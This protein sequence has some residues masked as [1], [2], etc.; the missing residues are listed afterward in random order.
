MD[1]TFTYAWDKYSCLRGA[2]FAHVVFCYFVALSG[3]ACLL[4][5]LWSRLHVAHAWL[6]RVY[7]LSMIWAMASSLLIHNTGLPT[8]T[9]VSFVWVLG[10]LTIGWVIISI[11][12]ARMAAAATAA[13]AVR[14]KVEGGVV[15]GGDLAALIA[16]ERGRL[17]ASKGFWARF[18][19]LKALHGS[20]M[21]VSWINIVGRIF[22]SNQSGDFTCYTYRERGVSAR[23][24]TGN[25]GNAAG[26][27]RREAA[28]LAGR[29]GGTHQVGPG[30]CGSV[31]HAVPAP[32]PFPGR[33][34][35]SSSLLQAD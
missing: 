23:Q 34:L 6:G 16:G 30:C 33:R 13:A 2:Y 20:L 29:T 5:R 12:R 7:I 19:S 27:L 17:A 11:H 10:G 15:P 32:S 28:L 22:A 14:I 18:V 1:P 31:D 8:A 3:F 26:W 21:F 4:T 25:R 24:H 9:L 35:R